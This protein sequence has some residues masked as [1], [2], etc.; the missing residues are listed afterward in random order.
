MPK[1]PCPVGPFTGTP[2]G[3]GGV[4]A[5]PLGSFTRA[6]RCRLPA[7]RPVRSLLVGRTA[8]EAGRVR[9]RNG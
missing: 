8:E 9:G 3:S 7:S 6:G 1:R 2:E 4:S 5:G